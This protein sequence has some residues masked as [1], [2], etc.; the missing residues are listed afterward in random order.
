MSVRAR[1]A[2]ETPTPAVAIE[3]EYWFAPHRRS[4]GLAR[5]ALRNRLQ[6]WGIGGEVADAAELLLSELVANAVKAS[7][8]PGGAGRDVGVRFTLAA[9][10]L[11]VEAVDGGDG[12]PVL[13]QAE[14]DDECGRGLAVVAAL[15][16]AWGVAPH[17]AGKAVWA[18]LTVTNSAV[19]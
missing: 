8:E 13:N 6:E 12:W 2:V 9:G 11:R 19:P 10:R 15:A 16:D 17:E 4:P 14:G 7:A 18:E 1:S 3:V 5:A